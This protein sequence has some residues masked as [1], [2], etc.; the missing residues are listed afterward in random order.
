M[1]MANGLLYDVRGVL[2]PD[3]GSGVRV[4]VLDVLA[5]VS[6]KST[7]GIEGSTPDGFAGQDT[8]PGFNE[9]DPRSTFGC[10]MEM[11]LRMRGEPGLDFR[12]CMRG[13]VIQDDVELFSAKAPHDCVQEPEKICGG[14]TLAFSGI[15]RQVLEVMERSGLVERIGRDRI[16]PTD[17]M[18]LDALRAELDA[19]A[20]PPAT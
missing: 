9:I 15:K 2:C 18:A 4:P 5:N 14:V 10:E 19:R 6:N 13:R 3:K 11:N 1:L 7:D 20:P 8:E 17:Q 16:F 12:G